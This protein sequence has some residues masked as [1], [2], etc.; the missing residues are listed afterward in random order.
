MTF[1]RKE[2]RQFMLCNERHFRI[3]AKRGGEAESAKSREG[4]EFLIWGFAWKEYLPQVKSRPFIKDVYTCSILFAWHCIC[5][6][7]LANGLHS[8]TFQGVWNVEH[9]IS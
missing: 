5:G 1:H 9:I 8:K 2:I 6:P 7:Q 3:L 4:G